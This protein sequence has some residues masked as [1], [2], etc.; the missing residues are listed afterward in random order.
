MSGTTAQIAEYL[1]GLGQSPNGANVSSVLSNLAINPGMIPGLR[2]A[3]PIVSPGDPQ[4]NGPLP[5]PPAPTR[6]RPV[7]AVTRGGSS[8]GSVGALNEVA[9]PP[10]QPTQ[11]NAQLPTPPIPPSAMDKAMAPAN[12]PAEPSPMPVGDVSKLDPRRLSVP[13]P[14]AG[15]PNPNASGGDTPP[16][17]SQAALNT[18]M[19]PQAATFPRPEPVSLPDNPNILSELYHGAMGIGRDDPRFALDT[20]EKLARMKQ[21]GM[22]NAL[23]FTS[24][25]LR[26]A[27]SAATPPILQIIR[28]YL[29]GAPRP[30]FGPPPSPIAAAPPVGAPAA[31]I[32]PPTGPLPTPWSANAGRAAP[33]AQPQP[34]V[35]PVGAKP[36]PWVTPPTPEPPPMPANAVQPAANIPQPPAPF[37]SGGTSGQGRMTLGGTNSGLEGRVVGGKF[38]TQGVPQTNIFEQPPVASVNIPPMESRLPPGAVTEPTPLQQPPFQSGSVGTRITQQG[39]IPTLNVTPQPSGG[40]PTGQGLPSPN[41]AVAPRPPVSLDELVDLVAP[42]R[43]LVPPNE[44]TPNTARTRSRPAPTESNRGARKDKTMSQVALERSRASTR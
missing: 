22:Q 11:P 35:P 23:S 32:V 5:A 4:F 25:G 12:G 33:T 41:L 21:I 38:T 7:T 15:G 13:T 26:N 44:V 43:N 39:G 30:Q 42:T 34:V 40:L 9:M 27:T 17:Q 29:G 28:E 31:P 10:K 36:S 1:R 3:E 20:P 14:T 18:R 19:G 8:Q 24:G 16:P 2:T 6:A 37:Q